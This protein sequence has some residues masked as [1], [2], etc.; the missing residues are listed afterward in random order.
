[1]PI[2]RKSLA[3][4]RRNKSFVPDTP[5]VVVKLNLN[6][7]IHKSIKSSK[8]GRTAGELEREFKN[9]NP[10]SIR[11]SVRELVTSELITNDV[12]CRCHSATIYHGVKK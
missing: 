6:Q 7:L 9:Y 5:K 11:Y 1:M 10:R 3:I 12:K 8:D 4:S 2:R